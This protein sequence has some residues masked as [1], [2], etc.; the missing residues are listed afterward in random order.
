MDAHDRTDPALSPPPDHPDPARWWRHRRKGYYTGIWWGIIQTP[1]WM[2]LGF[3][4]HEAV[5]SMGAVVGWSYGI[6]VSLILAYYGNTAIETW[7]T[8]GLR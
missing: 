7:A 6:C 1:A 5:M 2:I 8:R 4:E 3:F